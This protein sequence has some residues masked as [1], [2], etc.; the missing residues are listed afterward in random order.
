MKKYAIKSIT[1][2]QVQNNYSSIVE[3]YIRD[4]AHKKVTRLDLDRV[5]VGIEAHLI[6]IGRL[7][8]EGRFV[9]VQIEVTPLKPNSRAI[10]HLEVSTQTIGETAERYTSPFR[11]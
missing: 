1:V 2:D 5:E 3:S 6:V 7:K 10:S 9:L 4:H 11:S 8:N